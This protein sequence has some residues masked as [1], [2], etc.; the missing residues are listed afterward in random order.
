[1]INYIFSLNIFVSFH[2]G[3]ICFDTLY[4]FPTE[5]DCKDQKEN[6]ND[7]INYNDYFILTEN[8]A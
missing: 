2:Q 8:L 6:R 7:E 3:L 1:M 5:I 4:L